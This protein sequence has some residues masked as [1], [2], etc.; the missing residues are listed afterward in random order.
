M[1]H[2]QKT[3]LFVGALV[4]GLMGLYPPW[5]RIEPD[6]PA[7]PMGYGLLWD[8]PTQMKAERA[9]LFGI[10]LQL[11]IGPVTGNRIDWSRLLTQWATVGLITA[12]G[13][14]IASTRRKSMKPIPPEPR[15]ERANV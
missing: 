5:L 2:A 11:D 6:K 1:N 12:S 14:A 10:E 9:N 13:I 3:I 4:I 15:R 8:P 7:V